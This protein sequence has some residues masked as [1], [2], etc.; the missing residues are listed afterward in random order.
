M[1]LTFDP[2]QAWGNSR[3]SAAVEFGLIVPT[4]IAL[5]VGSLYLCM[6][7]LVSQHYLN[8]F[9]WLGSGAGCF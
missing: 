9:N 2:K 8:R 4:L 3:G 1:V 6:G 7:P 5:F